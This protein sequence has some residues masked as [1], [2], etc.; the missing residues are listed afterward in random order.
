MFMKL[1][2]LLCLVLIFVFALQLPLAASAVTNDEAYYIQK[3][4]NYYRYYQTG[5]SE[6][7]DSQIDALASR[8]QTQGAA[9]RK[10]MNTWEWVDQ[11][12]AVSSGILPYGLPQDDS[13]GIVVMGYSLNADGS[14]KSEMEDRL[15]VAL[16]SAQRYP[17]AYVICTGGATARYSNNTEAGVMAQWLQDWGISRDR[18]IVEDASYSTTQ[19]AKNT[20]A[21]LTRSYPE[22]DSLAVIS[23]NYHIY[24]SVLAFQAVSDYSSTVSGTDP[25]TVVSNATCWTVREDRES[26]TSQAEVLAAIAGLDLEYQAKPS[27]TGSSQTGSSGS[28]SANSSGWVS[29]WEGSQPSTEDTVIPPANPETNAPTVSAPS[30]GGAAVTGNPWLSTGFESAPQPDTAN[31]WG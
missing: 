6:N 19:N 17:N 30:T 1:R 9:W 25:I 3:M 26:L 7:I 13:L 20:Y 10:M 11:Y 27:L 31:P 2:R 4:L 12:M 15:I 5:A 24:R 21:L 28:A 22:I 8:N 29:Y 16:A 18:I 23:S 14:M